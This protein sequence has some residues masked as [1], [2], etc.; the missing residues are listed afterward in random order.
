[1][2]I[3]QLATSM[4]GKRIAAGEFERKVHIWDL[5]SWTRL[6]S[7]D[8][9]LDCGGQ[10]L[11]ISTDGQ[12]CVAGAYHIHGVVNYTADN[13]KEVWHRKDLKKPQRIRF[14]LD[15]TR[16]YIDIQDRSYHILD[17]YTGETLLKLNGVK[18]IYESPCQ[19]ILLF[20]KKNKQMELR[21][22]HNEKIATIPRATFT[23]LDVTFGAGHVCISESGGPTRCFETSSGEEIWRYEEESKHAL[24]LS[25]DTEK[26][27]FLAVFW[28][29]QTGGNLKLLRIHADSGSSEVISQLGVETETA[30]CENGTCLIIRKRGSSGYP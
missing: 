1:M 30:F 15:D 23:E 2:L 28:N 25:Y 3:R 29:Y 18:S 14:S 16:I 4:S 12:H 20:S 6:C 5:S 11:A 27:S 17:R 26:N 13:G 10:R 8:T 7:F 19:P 24:K 22:V 21:T 9:V